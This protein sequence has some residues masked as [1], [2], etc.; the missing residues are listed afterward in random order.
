MFLDLTAQK[1]AINICK[2]DN[3][4]NSNQVYLDEDVFKVDISKVQEE[5]AKLSSVEILES[6]NKYLTTVKAN[7]TPDASKLEQFLERIKQKDRELL[8]FETGKK[9]K[10]FLPSQFIKKS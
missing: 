10:N 9:R 6:T 7:D 2:M 4:K 5:R 8:E 3:V 1:K